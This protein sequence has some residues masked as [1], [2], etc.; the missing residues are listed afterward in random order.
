MRNTLNALDRSKV[1]EIVF[2]LLA[3]VVLCIFLPF[4]VV[5]VSAI[6]YSSQLS[7]AVLI[8]SLIAQHNS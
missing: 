6:H 7:S 4:P 5:C 8:S 2:S 1:R 3:S